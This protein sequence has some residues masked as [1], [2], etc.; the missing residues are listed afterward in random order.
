MTT[1]TA[2]LGTSTTN[3]TQ[4]SVATAKATFD[5]D[6]LLL[7]PKD[8]AVVVVP[9]EH[10]KA[11]LQ[12]A[13]QMAVLCAALTQ[14][15]EKL[16]QL[17]DKL[18]VVQAQRFP[19]MG[20]AQVL[21]SQIKQ[22]RK[23]YDEAY[24]NVKKELG[25][26]GYLATSGNGK[27]MLELIPLAQRKQGGKPQPWARKWT[28]VR[29]D[30]VSS[31]W[32][33]YSFNKPENGQPASFVKNG[34]VDAQELKK[35][36]TKLEPKLK[37][38]WSSDPVAGFW[39]PELQAWAEQ[40]NHK[41]EG[42]HVSF[43]YGVQLFRY[44]AGCGASAE[45]N[46]RGGK[47]AAKFNGKA[48]LMLASGKA[49][50]EGY[51][52]A[53]DGWVWTLTG[54]KSGKEFHI[55][56]VR[57][58]GEAKLEGACGASAAA[59]LGL[60]VDYSQLTGKSGVKG[61]KRKAASATG[62][63]VNANVGKLNELGAEAGL[64]GD[65]FAGA[66]LSGELTGA[67]QYKSPEVTNGKA[68]EFGAMAQVG[69]KVEVQFGAGAAAALMVHYDKGKFRLKAKAGVCLGP[70]AKGEIGLE[71]DAK[72]VYTFMEWLFRALLNANF[73]VL[74]I[75]TGEGYEAA[76]RLQAMWLN[77]VADVYDDINRAW[78]KFERRVELEDQRITLMKRVLS[79]PRELRIC[80]PEAHGIMLYQLTRH[81]TMT[82]LL[83]QN[84]GLNFEVMGERK[85]A[86]MQICR[87]AQSKRQFENMVQHIG[88]HGEKGGFKGNLQGLLRFM[89]IGPFNSRFDDELQSLYLSL[90]YE[91][92]RGHPLALNDSA[93]FQTY[94][95][96]GDSLP[97][98][99]LLNGKA[100][101]LSSATA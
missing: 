53:K 3:T 23:A 94:A 93:A 44:F 16:L 41:S 89:E 40:V 58:F 98:L 56:A 38:E 67:L 35:Q 36:F 61:A 7:N 25:D 34:K 95:R 82:K 96:M 59:E 39:F 100:M 45:W 30:K 46:P 78:D 60:E 33:S 69:P 27:E 90:P 91:P 65:L 63:D 5:A 92:P 6:L 73:E 57:F 32:R 84:T 50:T 43:E 70:G 19:S 52:P 76:M 74:E 9:K 62:A 11:F 101:P 10:A 68:D 2:V 72:R 54:P 4:G 80:L 64:G 66:K 75:V 99:A 21:Q 55:G 26:K 37:A 85:R 83:P 28:Y 20:D 77:G 29:S 71:V 79:N 17:E 87:W 97:Y 15:K 31:H 86:V 24:N 42:N 13:N 88:P 1:D 8:G 18:A 47:I 49:K 12:E 51:L 48:E 81:G 14:A 22:A